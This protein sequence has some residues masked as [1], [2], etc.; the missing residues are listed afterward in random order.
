[1]AGVVLRIYQKK[2]A[3]FPYTVMV[4]SC[5]Y[6]CLSLS[7]PDYQIARYNLNQENLNF[8]DVWYLMYECS[9]DVAPLIAEIDSD[10]ILSDEDSYWGNENLKN[11]IDLY[12]KIIEDKYED[13]S[14]REWNYAKYSALK[15]R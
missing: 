1:M 7:R 15:A 14:L 6:I 12:L 8:N 9:D 3:L 2:V 13:M 5:A 4:L 10:N 11:E